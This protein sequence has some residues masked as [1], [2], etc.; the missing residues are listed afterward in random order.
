MNESPSSRPN[1]DY[2]SQSLVYPAGWD[3]GKV[4]TKTLIVAATGHTLWS[5]L[6][7]AP[8]DG[9][10]VLAIKDAIV[11]YPD[12]VHHGFSQHADQLLHFI[13]IRKMRNPSVRRQ[14]NEIMA[15]TSNDRQY[16]G[17]HAWNLPGH[18]TSSLGAVYVG[19][20]LGYGRIVLCGCPL[21]DGGHYYD[22]PWVKTHFVKRIPDRSAGPRHWEHAAK[23]VFKG[24][25]KSM[26]GRT[27][28]LLGAP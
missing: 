9:A 23:C 10:D 7:E 17:V 14:A 1:L 28:E 2:V 20:A 24:R 12:P 19:L 11:H 18:G 26:S 21:D 15:H 3:C 22:P 27:R 8:T 13:E 16:P 4:K 25:V 5:D 6:R